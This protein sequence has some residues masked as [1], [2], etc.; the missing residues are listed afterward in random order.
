M[1]NLKKEIKK[2]QSPPERPPAGLFADLGRSYKTEDQYIF[3]GNCMLRT[4]L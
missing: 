3:L 4:R 2:Q 1:G